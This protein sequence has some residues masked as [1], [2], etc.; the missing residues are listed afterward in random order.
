MCVCVCVCVYVCVCV[1]VKKRN[2]FV[3][4]LHQV[5]NHGVS[6]RWFTETDGKHFKRGALGTITNITRSMV[7]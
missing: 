6:R 1:C 7:N 4:I 2:Y 5:N 3:F